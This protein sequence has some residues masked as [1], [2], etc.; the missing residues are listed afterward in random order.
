MVAL[1]RQGMD[2]RDIAQECGVSYF[3]AYSAVAD[4]LQPGEERENTRKMAY[5]RAEQIARMRREGQTYQQIADHYGVTAAA[6]R[7]TLLKIMTRE[8]VKQLSPRRRPREK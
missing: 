6:V 5:F 2:Y 1:R 3:D 7:N 4:V 8:Q